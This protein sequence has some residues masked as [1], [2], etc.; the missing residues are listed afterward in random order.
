MFSAAVIA[1][2]ARGTCSRNASPASAV[3]DIVCP[4]FSSAR[5]SRIMCSA[6]LVVRNTAVIGASVTG[7]STPLATSTSKASMHSS[8]SGT[9]ARTARFHD[10]GRQLAANWTRKLANAES[11]VNGICRGA[12]G[13]RSERSP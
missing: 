11:A 10:D 1:G 13:S 7:A 9:L 4:A 12:A 8:L 6:S 2:E 5:S 3:T